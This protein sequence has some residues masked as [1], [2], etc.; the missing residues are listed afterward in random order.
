[1]RATVAVGITALSFTVAVGVGHLAAAVISP[2]SSPYP[3]VAD[4]VV[5]FAPAGLVEFGKSLSAPGLP[6][7]QA[8][9]AGLLLGV[10]AV[11][12]VIAVLVGLG[13]RRSDRLG[14]R[15]VVMVGLLGVFA[16]VTSPTFG[17]IDLVAP[18]V[19][20][21]AGRRAFRYLH[22]VA[23]TP[24]AET[25]QEP[26]RSSTS[27]VGRRGLLA[28]AAAVGA[29][30]AGA[31]LAGC[32][33]GAGDGSDLRA[34]VAYRLRPIRPAPPIPLGAAFASQGTPTFL[35]PNQDFYRIDTALRVPIK[36][37]AN[38]SM[39][40]HGMVVRPL[41]IRYEDLLRRPLV[42]RTITMSC[43]SNTVG[44]GLISTANF[45]GVPLRDLL[46]EAGV[47]PEAD[48]L[49][50]TSLDGFTAGT[51]LDVILEPDRG[52]LLALGMNG[53][54]LPVEHG[55]PVRMVVPGLYGYVSA[56]KWL[57]DLDVTTFAA[58]QSYWLQRGWA[59][60]AP[61]KTESRID[62]PR[63]SAVVPA[64]RFVSAGV[65]WAQH[66][67][68]RTVEVQLDDAPW[69]P[70]RL[71]TQ[72]NTDTWRMWLAEL[73]VAPGEHTLRVRATDG[74]GEQQT[75]HTAAPVPDGASG[76]HT[77]HFSAR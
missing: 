17:Q 33:L 60:R 27:P 5:R 14:R 11:L 13:S 44:G 41:T 20:I 34:A 15:A 62:R 9:K 39:K 10:G 51:P 54:P 36:S 19:A 49:F 46:L 25:E 47:S 72:V 6:A 3:A 38:W 42:E 53:E 22:A 12:A 74:R 32:F 77:I 35:T 59:Q 45:I 29:G 28:S 66:R 61:I 18:I 37:A 23:S 58:R 52:A 69:R 56:T 40:V 21:A 55:F 67:G 26:A 31:G 1:L 70:A 73:D 48:Q 30:A 65:A 43:V 63:V 68:I 2:V 57:A 4:A 64:G 71:S 8:D 75:V 50:S 76:Y 16:V 7:G 24:A